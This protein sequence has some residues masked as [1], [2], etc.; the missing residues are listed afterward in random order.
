MYA[1]TRSRK[2]HDFL[3]KTVNLLA[4]RVGFRCSNPNCRK[5][6]SG[7]QANSLGA[8]NIGVAAHINAASEGGPRFDSAMSEAER[9]SGE[10]GIWLCQDCAKLIDSDV[11]RFTPDLLRRW[12]ALSEEAALLE[13]VRPGAGSRTYK[14]DVELLKFYAVCLDR[15]AFQ[16]RFARSE[17]H[18]AHF[19][20]AIEDT[21]TAINTG[22]LY[23]RDGRLLKRARGK[24]YLSNPLWREKM[25]AIVSLLRAI[26]M[27]FRTLSF[28]RS[29]VELTDVA[30]WMDR[31]RLEI[32][33]I[34]AEL[35]REAGITPPSG[36]ISR[37]IEYLA[38]E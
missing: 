34:F 10:N 25:D 36:E 27:R 14:A 17:E 9:R 12:R 22:V 28:Y 23:N 16:D 7:P 21:I 33:R 1:S 4:R 29:G 5:L 11:N 32:L 37:T 31:T 24:I 8:I 20:K 35:C 18:L 38:L 15:P 30:R 2:R 3:A 6:T 13:L 26:R 19:D